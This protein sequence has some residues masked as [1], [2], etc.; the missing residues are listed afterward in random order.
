MKSGE[1]I[2]FMQGKMLGHRVPGLWI[3]RI[4]SHGWIELTESV[5]A[6]VISYKHRY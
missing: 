6:L 4:A 1:E 5:I 2:V 3:E